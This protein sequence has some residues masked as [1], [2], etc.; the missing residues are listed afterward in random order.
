[1]PTPDAHDLYGHPIGFIDLPP[2][3]SIYS[4]HLYTPARRGT[5]MMVESIL[6][7]LSREQARRLAS[8]KLI[9]RAIRSWRGEGRWWAISQQ[10]PPKS[11]SG[12]A[13]F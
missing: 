11:I 6:S 7:I 1:M 4:Q 3:Y 12:E 9:D 2:L 5:G 8:T 10:P 13:A